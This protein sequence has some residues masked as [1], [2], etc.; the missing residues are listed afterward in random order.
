MF[1]LIVPDEIPSEPLSRCAVSGKH[2]QAS[3]PLRLAQEQAKEKDAEATHYPSRVKVGRQPRLSMARRSKRPRANA[4]SRSGGPSIKSIRNERRRAMQDNSAKPRNF[5]LM[6][7]PGLSDEARKAVK[8]AFD[9]MSTWR[10]ET[11]EN[12]EKNSERVIEKMA[13]AARALGWP[14]Q[15]VDAT[16]AQIQSITKM[17]IQTM[18]HMMDAWEEQIRSPNPMTASSAMLSK[19]KSPGFGPAGSGPNAEAF[20][21]AAMNPMQFWMQ[22]AGQCQKAWADSMSAMG[23]GRQ[24]T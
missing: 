9:A 3:R 6:S 18:D 23:K 15:I 1:R 2:Q 17:Q 8:A 16:R 13:A 11:A 24:G 4:S 10:I 14:E 20:P 19:L 22:F 7:V 12:T 21:M 5:D